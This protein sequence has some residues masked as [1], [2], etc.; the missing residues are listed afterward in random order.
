MADDKFFP[1]LGL[2]SLKESKESTLLHNTFMVFSKKIGQLSFDQKCIV[3]IVNF[4]MCRLK[5]SNRFFKKL[6][7][8]T[9]QALNVCKMLCCFLFRF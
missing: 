4:S 5:L 2:S 3:K 7:A 8:V 1:T 6:L 9:L